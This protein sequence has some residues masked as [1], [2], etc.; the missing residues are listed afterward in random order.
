MS[1]IATPPMTPE[2]KKV[3]MASSLGTIVNWYDF[4]IYGS[5]AGVMSK[6]FFSNLDPTTAFTLVLLAWAAGFIARPFGALVFGRLGDRVGRKYTFL[7]TIILMSVATFSIGVLPSFDTIGYAAPIILV[8]F[9]VLQGLAVGGEY[10]GAA[11]YVAES[12][13]AKRRGA[14][15]GWVQAAA[16]GGLLLSMLVILGVRTFLTEPVFADWGW[17]LPFLFSGVLLIGAVYARRNM[18]DSPVFTQMKK[19][20]KISKDPLKETFTN[21]GNLKQILIAMFGPA[22]AAGVVWYASTLYPL[23]FLTKVLKVDGTTATMMIVIALALSFPFFIWF[24]KLSDAVGRKSLIILGC[25]L[26]ITTYFPVFHAIAGAANPALVK[27]QSRATVVL[28]ADADDC[29]FQFNPFGTKKFT[30]SCDIAKQLL[31]DA[32]VSYKTQDGAAGSVA[33]LT[34]SKTLIKSYTAVGLSADEAKTK[35]GEFKTEVA[36]AL[37]ASSYPA[38][39]DAKK[40][41]HVTIVLLLLYMSIVAAMVYGPSAALMTEMFPSQIRYTSM[42]FSYHLATGWLGGLLPTTAFAIVAQTGNSYNGLWY[43]VIISAIS[44]IVFAFF[45]KDKYGATPLSLIKNN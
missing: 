29:S 11:I 22:A 14:F 9:R 40:I 30:S 28:I 35:A 34:I 16:T 6:Q 37:K 27:A 39:A 19:E 32:A 26:A 17:R 10:G 7:A 15:T 41:S 38:A 5:L 21:R 13:P 2:Q 45:V 4:F 43:P 44:V 12:A 31:A 3:V 18:K 25:V 36:A 1:N 23:F 24:G 42:S 8:I 20:G 33:E